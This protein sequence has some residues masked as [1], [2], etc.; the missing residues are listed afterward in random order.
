MPLDAGTQL[1]P[2]EIVSAIGA[3]GEVSADVGVATPEITVV[4]NWHQELLERVPIP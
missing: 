2:Y 3:G 1:G 4:L